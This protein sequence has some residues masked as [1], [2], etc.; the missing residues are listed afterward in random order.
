[1][2]AEGDD[3]RDAIDGKLPAIRAFDCGVAGVPLIMELCGDLLVKR[4]FAQEIRSP[5][6]QCHPP[7]APP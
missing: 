2:A 3:Y 5:V 1:M 7:L 6:D 4:P